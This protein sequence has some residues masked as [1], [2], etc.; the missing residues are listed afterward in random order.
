M[1]A[2]ANHFLCGGGQLLAFDLFAGP[3]SVRLLQRM[4]EIATR[5]RAIG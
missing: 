4:K 2:A 1:C 5:T 3:R